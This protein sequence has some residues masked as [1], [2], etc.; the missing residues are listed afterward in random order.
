[1]MLVCCSGCARHVR[2]DEDACPFCGSAVESSEAACAPKPARSRL[3]RVAAMAAG[4][5]MVLSLSGCPVYGAPPEDFDS[6]VP[7]RVDGG[8]DAG[9]MDAGEPADAAADD[10]GQPQDSGEPEDAGEADGGG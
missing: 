1:M 9:G 2:R 6:S 7:P 5:G 8:R 3:G 4:A 10:G